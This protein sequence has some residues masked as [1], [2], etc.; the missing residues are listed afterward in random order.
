MAL[1][2]LP[3]RNRTKFPAIVVFPQCPENQYWAPINSRNDGFSY[4]NT[5]NLTEPM[6]W[7]YVD[8]GI[9]EKRGC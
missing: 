4:V 3:I 8:K 9:K 7:L 6:Q 2:Y 1:R 5:K